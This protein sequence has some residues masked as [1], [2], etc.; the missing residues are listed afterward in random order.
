MNDEPGHKVTV[1]DMYNK[2][3]SV[4]DDVKRLLEREDTL[5]L[6]SRVA[7]LEK[8]VYWVGIPVGSLS[9]V[10]LGFDTLLKQLS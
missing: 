8:I 7:R 2:L 5:K 3:E 1:T 10:V 6:G 9:A 4:G